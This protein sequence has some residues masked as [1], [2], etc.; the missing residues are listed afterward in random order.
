M[1]VL[2][3]LGWDRWLRIRDLLSFVCLSE[4]TDQSHH[5]H[6]PGAP[7]GGGRGF[8]GFVTPWR[9]TI[10]HFHERRLAEA[11]PELAFFGEGEW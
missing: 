2:L 11:G 5:A 10:G 3:G 1:V 9:C 6:H 7:V 4:A 8:S